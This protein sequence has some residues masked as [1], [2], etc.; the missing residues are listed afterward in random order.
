M[1]LMLE[2][3]LQYNKTHQNPEGRQLICLRCR[4]G[5]GASEKAKKKK[6]K[7]I[8]DQLCFTCWGHDRKEAKRVKS[9]QKYPPP[10]KVKTMI[11]RWKRKGRSAT[12]RRAK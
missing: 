1:A 9:V 10:S 6:L 7:P 2:D 12:I 8:K 11:A 5:N 4:G 3:W